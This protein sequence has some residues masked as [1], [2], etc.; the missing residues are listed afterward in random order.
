MIYVQ[1][2]RSTKNAVT[3]LPINLSACAQAYQQVSNIS[4]VEFLVQTACSLFCILIQT[5]ILHS[6]KKTRPT[7]IHKECINIPI[8]LSILGNPVY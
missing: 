7:C 1:F 4:D 8:F 5:H 2:F 3:C 6:S